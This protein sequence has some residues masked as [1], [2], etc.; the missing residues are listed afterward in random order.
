MAPLRT[1][2]TI[3]MQTIG[4]K[5]LVNKGKLQIFLQKELATKEIIH[6][7]LKLFN[8]LSGK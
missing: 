7:D 2:T 1:T 3:S 8:I 4:E 6:I 5:K